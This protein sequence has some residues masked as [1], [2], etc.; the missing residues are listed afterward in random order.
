MKKGKYEELYKL[1]LKGHTMEEL[2]HMY[3]ITRQAISHMFKKRGYETRNSYWL[4]NRNSLLGTITTEE[5]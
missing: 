1:Y 3:G 5:R 4:K 2:A